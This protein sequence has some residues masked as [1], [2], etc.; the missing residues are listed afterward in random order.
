LIYY[1]VIRNTSEHFAFTKV[2]QNAG[3]CRLQ[4]RFFYTGHLHQLAAASHLSSVPAP[5]TLRPA[6]C[7]CKY[8]KYKFLNKDDRNYKFL[9]I[10][11]F[12]FNS[13]NYIILFNMPPDAMPKISEFQLLVFIWHTNIYFIFLR[14]YI[15]GI[16]FAL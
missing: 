3:G 5:C 13:N 8:R 10:N 16:N 4:S 15:D 12:S 7:T 14:G 1:R 9:L 6:P 11:F 2:L